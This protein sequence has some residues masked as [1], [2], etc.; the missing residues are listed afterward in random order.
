MNRLIALLFAAG[1]AGF[2]LAADE[3]ALLEDARKVASLPIGFI[4]NHDFG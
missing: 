2:A 4:A 3:A 1:F